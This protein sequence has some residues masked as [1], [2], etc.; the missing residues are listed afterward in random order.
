MNILLL[1]EFSGVHAGL[2]EGLSALGHEITL[3]S[4]S[5]GYKKIRGADISFDPKLSGIAGKIENRLRPLAALPRLRG[6]DVVQLINPFVFDYPGF[7]KEFF[8]KRSKNSRSYFT[9]V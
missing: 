9:A 4:T 1:G 6:F 7:P 5:D 3:A 2:K 8:I